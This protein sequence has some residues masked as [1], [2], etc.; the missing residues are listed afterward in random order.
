MNGTVGFDQP[1]VLWALLIFIPLLMMDFLRREN[2]RRAAFYLAPSFKGPGTGAPGKNFSRRRRWIGLCFH[3]FLA[4]MIIALAG[5]RWGSRMVNSYR[6]GLDLVLALDLSRSM[7]VRDVPALP[8]P[9][10][11]PENG[12][13]SR[14]ERALGL[15]AEVVETAGGFRI[16]AALGRGR[17]ILALPLTYDTEGALNFLEGLRGS[18]ITGRGTNLEALTDAA[19]G[20]FQDA[21]PGRRGII[22]ITDG[23]SLSGTL[24]AALERVW[25]AGITLSVLGMGTDTGGPVPLEEP[26][27]GVLLD[28]AGKTVI[29]YRRTEILRDAAARTG[30]IYMDGNR[31]DAAGVLSAYL[32]S[33]SSGTGPGASRREPGSRWHVFVIAGLC[34]WGLSRLLSLRRRRAVTSRA[35]SHVEGADADA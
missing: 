3:L 22:L 5:P 2:D 18:A 24:G 26:E 15:A 33:L 4:C 29:S 19:T 11:P 28:N 21:F 27:E 16:G 9:D 34:F 13:I 20:A 32:R 7:E 30:G 14:L 31:D 8:R 25:A 35:G 12:P 1:G 6:R 17:G 10:S 23:E